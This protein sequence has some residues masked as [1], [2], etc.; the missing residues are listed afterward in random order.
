MQQSLD[1]GCSKQVKYRL[2][3]YKVLLYRLHLYRV[4]L[5]R[6]LV[7]IVLVYIVLLYRVLLY[8][9]LLY[10]WAVRSWHI[11]VSVSST[12]SLVS[13]SA[14]LCQQASLH[15]RVLAL[16]LG[17]WRIEVVAHHASG[18]VSS[19]LHQLGTSLAP[20][21]HQLGRQMSPHFG[22]HMMCHRCIALR[23]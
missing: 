19:R 5:H 2:L 16:C 17:C 18:G 14:V 21:W 1:T 13:V 20:D 8:R 4:L 11:G 15:C 10:S 9:V 22:S 7:Y 23:R 3:L 6:V 12:C